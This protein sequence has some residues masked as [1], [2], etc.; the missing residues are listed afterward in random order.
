MYWFVDG[1]RFN[2]ADYSI[3][4]KIYISNF[5]HHCLN[6]IYNLIVF[7]LNEYGVILTIRS[8][9]YRN[10]VR[11]SPRHFRLEYE[12]F[13]RSV[14]EVNSS[15]LI[16]PIVPEGFVQHNKSKP[17]NVS[18]YRCLRRAFFVSVE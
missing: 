1:F 14:V 4:M 15:A 7:R 9:S 18:P 8:T 3:Y 11:L 13:T 10:N 16:K 2:L 17:M 12:P 6:N 5:F